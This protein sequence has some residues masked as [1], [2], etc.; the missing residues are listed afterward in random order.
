MRARICSSSWTFITPEAE[1][2]TPDFFFSEPPVVALA[3]LLVHLFGVR[4]VAG[5]DLDHVTFLEVVRD[6]NRGAGLELRGLRSGGHGVA[7]RRARGLDDL[8][9]HERRQLDADRALVEIHDL[10]DQM[11]LQEVL[12]LA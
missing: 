2:A 12:A 11:L 4:V 8:E 5:V 6:L 10:D 1:E 7:A 9:L 3:T